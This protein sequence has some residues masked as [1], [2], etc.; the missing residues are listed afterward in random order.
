[1]EQD[2]AERARLAAIQCECLGCANTAT[3]LRQLALE[4]EKL[5]MRHTVNVHSDLTASNPWFKE[6]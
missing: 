3:A 2:L 5:P 1:M 4:F 6:K